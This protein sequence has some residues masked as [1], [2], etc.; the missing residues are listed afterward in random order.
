MDM[1]LNS[2]TVMDAPGKE[3]A[4]YNQESVTATRVRCKGNRAP[5]VRQTGK[6]RDSVAQGA[7]FGLAG[8]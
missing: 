2:N 8:R 6:V 5:G 3:P 7:R 4:G 1:G